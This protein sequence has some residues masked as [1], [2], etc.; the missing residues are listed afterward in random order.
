MLCDR[1]LRP[2]RRRKEL[3]GWAT[4]FSRSQLESF[5]PSEKFLPF[6]RRIFVDSAKIAVTI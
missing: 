1:N 2:A 4:S 6:D 3:F 5:E